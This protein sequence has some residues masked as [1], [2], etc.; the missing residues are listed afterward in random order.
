MRIVPAVEAELRREIRDARALDPLIGVAALEQHL[1]KKFKRGFSYRYV[2]KLAEKVARQALIEADRTKIEERLA[3]TR[4]NYRLIRE[5]LM[6]IVYWERDPS[7]PLKMQLPPSDEDVINAAKNIVMLDLALLKAEIECG[8]Y[9]RPVEEI[10]KT[11]R[12]EPLPGE[13]RVAV[14]AAWTRGGLLPKATVETMVPALS[15]QQASPSRA[16]TKP[17][18]APE[19]TASEFPALSDRP[20]SPTDA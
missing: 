15:V 13:V 2:A 20:L 1:E 16:E 17:H 5:R 11:F 18:P 6:K 3:F 12:Y 10:A 4:E 8:L 14:I 7:I 9:Q 19:N